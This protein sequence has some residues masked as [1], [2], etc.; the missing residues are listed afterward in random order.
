MQDVNFWSGKLNA[1]LLFN[2]FI[3][4]RVHEEE[5][6]N[7]VIIIEAKSDLKLNIDW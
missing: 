4:F 1:Q 2:S 3:R 6:Q 7:P 5:N